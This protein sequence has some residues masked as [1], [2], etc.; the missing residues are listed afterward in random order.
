MDAGSF[1]V[2]Q[3]DRGGMQGVSAY[4]GTT[5]ASPPV[6]TRLYT[7]R[8]ALSVMSLD[9]HEFENRLNGKPPE[10]RPE[11]SRLGEYPPQPIEDVLSGIEQH[12]HD[13]TMLH[14]RLAGR[15]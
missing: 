2:R 14:Q 1:A 4:N 9:L 11:S 7:I 13:I 10:P 8:Q 3:A 5:P 6:S 12:I 15:F